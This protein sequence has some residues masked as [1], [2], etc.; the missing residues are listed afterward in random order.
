MNWPVFFKRLGS[1]VIFC[2]VI[3]V[4]LTTTFEVLL[5]VTMLIQFLCI[6]ESWQ[7]FK[8]IFPDTVFPNFLYVLTQVF[9]FALTLGIAMAA[10]MGSFLFLALLIPVM[11]IF[12][13]VLHPKNTIKA[14]L[15]GLLSI[16]YVSIPL[17][18]MISMYML[19]HSAHLPT[20]IPLALILLIWTNDTMAYI[21]GSFI[22]KTPFSQISPKKTWEGTIGG[23][24]FT[25]L[26]VVILS[27]ANWLPG[28]SLQDWIVLALLAAIIGTIGDL[29]ESKLKRMANV[30]DSGN[31]MPGHGGALDRFDS[32]LAALPFAFCYVLIFM[33]K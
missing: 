32:L 8:N 25:V 2:A 14:G 19:Y 29:V 28:L 11:L 12:V 31:I 30:K 16:F 33:V 15:S 4:A 13:S 26:S 27:Y 22:G 7:L 1:A 20:N 21:T 9:G 6:K 23:V 17:G 10:A 24:V 5:A 3:L 18:G